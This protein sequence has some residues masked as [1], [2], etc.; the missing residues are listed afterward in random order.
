M[1][2]SQ[3]KT[4]Q[5]VPQF[6][7]CYKQL[8]YMGKGMNFNEKYYW[9]LCTTSIVWECSIRFH[10]IWLHLVQV[11]KSTK[12]INLIMWIPCILQLAHFLFICCTW[13][14]SEN[15]DIGVIVNDGVLFF[16]WSLFFAQYIA[17]QILNCVSLNYTSILLSELESHSSGIKLIFKMLIVC[18]TDQQCYRCWQ[19][20]SVE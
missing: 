9:G 20:V 2:W 12:V 3:N 18:L 11:L 4:F 16:W 17:L 1:F 15:P 14:A 5:P 19:N 6:T 8:H 13:K 10:V 7:V